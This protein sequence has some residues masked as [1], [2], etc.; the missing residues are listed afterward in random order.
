MRHFSSALGTARPNACQGG[1]LLANARGD[2]ERKY[3]ELMQSRRCRLIVVAISTGGRWSSEALDFI[4]KLAWAKAQ[5]APV[6]LRA[7]VAFSWQRRWMRML[8]VATASAFAH[9]LVS[10][11]KAGAL[12][13]GGATLELCEL[14]A[15]RDAGSFCDAAAGAGGVL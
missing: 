10:P 12:S 1:V 7:S 8:S 9:S 6:Y 4:H 14:F 3:S 13:T 11:T 2:K 15:S 5:A